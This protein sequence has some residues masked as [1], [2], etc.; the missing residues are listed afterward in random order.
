VLLSAPQ[1]PLEYVL[2]GRGDPVTIFGHGLGGTIA[3]TRPFASAVPGTRAFFH[4][5]GHGNSFQPTEFPGY[6]GL[7]TDLATV[8]DHVGAT[9]ALG[10]SM[11]AAALLALVS[12]QPW[13]FERLVFVLPAVIDA[14]RSDVVRRRLA[15]LSAAIADDT[16]AEF[17]R[18]EI[19]PAIRNPGDY[20][21]ARAAA[22]SRL[23]E[24]VRAT[25]DAIAVP[26]RSALAK[27]EAP[28]LVVGA[29]GDPLHD[30]AVAHDLA[31][32]LPDARLHVFPEPGFGW[33]RRAELRDVIGGFLS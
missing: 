12:A 26:D 13:R 16:L 5:Q 4:F 8:A 21:A 28:A 33:T 15:E 14:V 30:V 9:R 17:V 19:P 31:G 3:Q 29:I 11:G 1:G 18:T 24:F 20:V 22:L 23:G 32:L 10:V 27:V 7:A 6:T 2:A 25:A